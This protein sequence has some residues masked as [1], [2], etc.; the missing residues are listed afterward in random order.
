[1]IQIRRIL[2][3]SIGAVTG[4][5]FIKSLRKASEPFYI[6]GADA[7]NFA[8]GLKFVDKNYII[9][10]ASDEKN[11]ISTLVDICKKE[12]IEVFVPLID[13]E[14]LVVAKNFKEFEK[15]GVKV[16]LSSYETVR[17]C[18]DKFLTY[19]KLGDELFI[20]TWRLKDLENYE[21]SYPVIMKPSQGR[22]TKDIFLCKNEDEIN[23]LK[24][25]V[26][27]P[28]IQEYMNE[29]EYTVDILSDLKG[30]PIITIPRIRKR[31]KAG[32]TWQGWVDIRDDVKKICEKA[33]RKLDIIGPSCVQV[34]FTSEGKP[35]IFEINP[36][37]GGTTILTVYS[38]ANIPYMAFKLFLNE[39]FDLPSKNEINQNIVISRYFDEVVFDK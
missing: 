1:V 31:T 25:R 19:K 28:I 4:L 39:K 18:L 22:G 29:P 30:N 27:N 26:D 33:V 11:Y 15:I 36:R 10:M 35:K 21:F 6:V 13:E 32:V 14:L 5:V 7:D 23:V 17:N 34:R 8:P 16:T 37:I 2:I 12:K 20:K 24:N 9:P 3:S 38:G